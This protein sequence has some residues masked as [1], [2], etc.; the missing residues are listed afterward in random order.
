MTTAPGWAPGDVATIALWVCAAISTVS[1]TITVVV[2]ALRA[3][4]KPEG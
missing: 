4:K 1:G 3:A 2:N